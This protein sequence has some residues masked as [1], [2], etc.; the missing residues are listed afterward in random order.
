MK[1]VVEFIDSCQLENVISALKFKPEKVVYIGFN[2]QECLRELEIIK[3]FFK[4]RG[5]SI[6]VENVTVNRYNYAEIVQTLKRVARENPEC[7]FDLTGGKELA[8]VAMGEVYASEK[9]PMFQVDIPANKVIKVASCQNLGSVENAVLSIEESVALN[10]GKVLESKRWNINKEF[11]TDINAVWTVAKKD[12]TEWN[13]DVKR[14]C[15]MEKNHARVAEYGY[16]EIDTE[17]ENCNPDYEFINRLNQTGIIVDYKRISG[18]FS[19]SYKDSIVREILLKS[20]NILELYTYWAANE[21]AKAD[22]GFFDFIET[23]V[24]VDW[25]TEEMKKGQLCRTANEIDV[26]MMRD[27]VPIFVSCK[28][29][30]VGKEA[31]YELDTVTEQLGGK[32]AK[33]IL[34]ATDI[35]NSPSSKTLFL[36]RAEDMNIKVITDVHRMSFEEFKQMLSEAAR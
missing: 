30:K 9:M 26:V 35:S 14:L 31:L 20:G 28:C 19:Y 15:A 1:T 11:V 22:T 33:K 16:Y 4:L 21:I 2:E 23:G 18:G 6:K 5:D 13:N 34:V 27:T 10:G 7:A 12:F 25:G 24:M 29:G 8:L 36:K 17:D 32:Y 3:D